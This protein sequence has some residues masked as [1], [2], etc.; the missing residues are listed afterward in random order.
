MMDVRNGGPVSI[1][2]GEVGRAETKVT[3]AVA[4]KREPDAAL[5]DEPQ[6]R[7][8]QGDVTTYG[9][10]RPVTDDRHNDTVSVCSQSSSAV[11]SRVPVTTFSHSGCLQRLSR[12]HSIMIML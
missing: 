3:C 6:Q 4:V 1:L 2:N 10:H 11:S 9:A 7:T 5:I 12:L 8:F